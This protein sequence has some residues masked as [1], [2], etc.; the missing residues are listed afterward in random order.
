MDGQA[1]RA[2]GPPAFEWARGREVESNWLWS[3]GRVERFL[4][5]E[6]CG[7]G[8]RGL[9]PSPL[10]Q[11][12]AQMTGPVR[13]EVKIGPVERFRP[14]SAGTSDAVRVE[15]GRAGGDVRGSGLFEFFASPE[16]WPPVGGD[17]A[18]VERAIGEGL[19]AHGLRADEAAECLSEMAGR[20]FGRAGRRIVVIMPRGEM[21]AYY[22]CR[23]APA[24][25]ERARVGV[26]IADF[27]ERR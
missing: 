4:R 22:A 2:V 7:N 18:G 10:V 8:G 1:G 5:V 27:D 21:D 12:V 15:V 17:R 19:V 11:T 9:P 26:V 16:R 25:T 23:V 20:V 24:P 13:P 3:G 14:A 6:D